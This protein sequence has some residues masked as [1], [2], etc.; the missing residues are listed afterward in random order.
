MASGGRRRGV[1]ALAAW[2]ALESLEYLVRMKEEGRLTEADVYEIEGVV[3]L[4]IERR[5]RGDISDHMFELVMR[6][7]AEDKARDW[8]ARTGKT[9][10]FLL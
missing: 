3:D 5:Q 2:R 4:L 1:E 7:L 9:G 10:R 6:K 8:C